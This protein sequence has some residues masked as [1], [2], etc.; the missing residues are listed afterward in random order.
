MESEAKE[1]KSK[2]DDN[3]VSISAEFNSL[4]DLISKEKEEQIF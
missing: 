1:N 3:G 2:E 4:T